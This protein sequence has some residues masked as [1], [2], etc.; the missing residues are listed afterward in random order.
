M[1]SSDGR[2]GVTPGSGVWSKQLNWLGLSLGPWRQG[3]AWGDPVRAGTAVLG[4]GPVGL[5]MGVS[6]LGSECPPAG[7]RDLL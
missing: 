7:E 3:P 5:E 2:L 6:F 1:C 4:W